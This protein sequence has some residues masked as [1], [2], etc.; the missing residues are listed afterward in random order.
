M[1]CF[2]M[3]NPIFKHNMSLFFASLAADRVF[4]LN[5]ATPELLTIPVLKFE[6]VPYYYLWMCQKTWMSGK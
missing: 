3:T 2:V 6:Q 5:I 4:T 1:Y